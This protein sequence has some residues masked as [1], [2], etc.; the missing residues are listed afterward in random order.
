VPA[1]VPAVP[2]GPK[3][4]VIHATGEA[5]IQVSDR[6]RVIYEATLPPG[7][8]YEVPASAR[9]PVLR[10][11]NSGAV[12]LLV[13]GKTYGPLGRPRRLAKN[14]SLVADDIRDNI[15]VAE[16]DLSQ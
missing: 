13:G 12:Y 14:V 4:A 16:V 1:P 7:G 15:P 8:A 6:G 11:G 2:E 5:W 3:T 10:A 9:A